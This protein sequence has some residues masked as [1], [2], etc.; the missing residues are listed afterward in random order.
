MS[1]CHIE[2]YLDFIKLKLDLLVLLLLSLTFLI[3][4]LEPLQNLFK[5]LNLIGRGFLN[6]LIL[7]PQLSQ[8][9]ALV[10]VLYFHLPDL[11]LK[12][13]NLFLQQIVL[14]FEFLHLLL[15]MINWWVRLSSSHL[16]LIEGLSFVIVLKGDVIVIL[17]WLIR[18]ECLY[19]LV[20]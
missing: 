2:L 15:I 3:N 11:W 7:L 16:W 18:V 5:S 6:I 17:D 20:L 10:L 12:G 1:P 19:G 9:L 13:F 14:I 8:I 4:L